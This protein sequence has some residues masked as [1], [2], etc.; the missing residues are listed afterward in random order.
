MTVNNTG[1]K[2]AASKITKFEA[3]TINHQYQHSNLTKEKAM[4]QTLFF[5]LAAL[6]ALTLGCSKSNP[7]DSGDGGNQQPVS[8]VTSISLDLDS[9]SYS[10]S[11]DTIYV[12]EKDRFYVRVTVKDQNGNAMSARASVKT[13]CG[14]ATFLNAIT[15]ELWKVQADS[16]ISGWS[17]SGQVTAEIKIGDKTLV[18]NAI[19]ITVVYKFFYGNFL[20]NETLGSPYTTSCSQVGNNIALGS[21]PPNPGKLTGNTFWTDYTSQG[22]NRFIYR[23]TINNRNQASGTVTINSTNGT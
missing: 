20:F 22:G 6:V 1:R 2:L 14:T 13:N 8:V 9:G 16:L 17:K 11:G 10:Q 21:S 7:T 18:S 5:A 3:K 15:T 19:K 23:G 4:K 12:A